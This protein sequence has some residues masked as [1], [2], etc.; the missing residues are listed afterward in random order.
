MKLQFLILLTLLMS[1]HVFAK[2]DARDP[3]SN[4][5]PRWKCIFYV[6]LN[7]PRFNVGCFKN[8]NADKGTGNLLIKNAEYQRSYSKLE[9]ALRDAIITKDVKNQEIGR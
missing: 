6:G 3:Q 8:Y 4:L 7:P 9:D 1:N 5:R 2:L